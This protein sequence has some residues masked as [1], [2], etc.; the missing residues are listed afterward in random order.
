[1][2]TPLSILFY[3]QGVAAPLS[4]MIFVKCYTCQLIVTNESLV[5]I[6]LFE[7]SF[8]I[9][10]QLLSLTTLLHSG[11]IEVH[12]EKFELLS[13]SFIRRKLSKNGSIA[14]DNNHGR[15]ILRARSIS[16]SWWPLREHIH[17]ITQLAL[18]W[19]WNAPNL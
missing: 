17:E 5:K 16:G 15:E 10:P 7:K 2:I 11:F 19:L 13:T 8:V 6:P 14:R 18:S 12:H 3:K 1:M 4:A 9:S